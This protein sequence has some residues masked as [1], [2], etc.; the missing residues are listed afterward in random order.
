NEKLIVNP[1]IL[2]HPSI[3]LSIIFECMFKIPW[4]VGKYFIMATRL[5]PDFAILKE[6][7][8]NIYLNISSVYIA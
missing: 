3:V 4:L 7:I 6:I 5:V 2:N 8:K 1:E